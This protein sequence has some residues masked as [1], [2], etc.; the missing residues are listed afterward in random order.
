M[1][2]LDMVVFWPLVQR[3]G[4]GDTAWE[5]LQVIDWSSMGYLPCNGMCRTTQTRDTI[6]QHVY[7]QWQLLRPSQVD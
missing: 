5:W 4:N 2:W 7:T 3:L 1:A 6:D